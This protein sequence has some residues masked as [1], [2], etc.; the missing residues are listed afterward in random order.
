[1]LSHCPPGV[2]SVRPSIT[3]DLDHVGESSC[4]Q[5]LLNSSQ[6]LDSAVLLLD[7]SSRPFITIPSGKSAL[8]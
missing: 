6:D 8:P 2:L 4:V 3:Y 1:V 5:V 7:N